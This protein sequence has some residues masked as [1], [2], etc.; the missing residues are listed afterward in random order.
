MGS[1]EKQQ[2]DKV[3]NKLIWKNS[4]EILNVSKVGYGNLLAVLCLTKVCFP[5]VEIIRNAIDVL[6]FA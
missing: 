6:T 3:L 1:L 4:H 2:T 5:L